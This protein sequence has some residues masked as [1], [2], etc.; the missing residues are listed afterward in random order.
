MKKNLYIENL[1]K[2]IWAKLD[3]Q[4]EIPD[5]IN[6][7]V[8]LTTQLWPSVTAALEKNASHVKSTNSVESAHRNI[9]TNNSRPQ[10]DKR[11]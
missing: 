8:A 1:N 10:T 3:E 9:K 4:L 5:D 2:L 7:I 11:S 6:E